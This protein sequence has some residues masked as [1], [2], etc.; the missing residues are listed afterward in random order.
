MKRILAIVTVLFLLVNVTEG[1]ENRRQKRQARE[2]ARM[3]EILLLYNRGDVRFIAQ[4]AQPMGGGTIHLTSEY[5]L[6]IHGDTITAYLPYFGVA[7]MV[8]YGAS[9]GGIKFSEQVRS[10]RWE[11]TKNGYRILMEVKAPG[12]LYRLHLTFSLL[13]YA[14][15]DVT[16]QNRQPIHFS[17]VIDKRHVPE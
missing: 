3:E 1:K 7:Y 14:N 10:V 6:D 9:E 13:G 11:K 4:M 17:G 12:D 16:S 2:K 8:D 5:T 15:L